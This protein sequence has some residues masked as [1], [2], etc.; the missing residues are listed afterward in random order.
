[1]NPKLLPAIAALL[2]PMLL[3]QAPSAQAMSIQSQ[4]GVA[5]HYNDRFQG[6]PTASGEPYD[7]QKY[8][9]AHKRL[10]L[11]T[12]VRV[13]SLDTGKSTLVR[14]NDRGP[15]VQGR[16]IDLS[17]R[18]ARDL[19]LLKTGVGRVRIEVIELPSSDRT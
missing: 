3:T 5:S 2:L 9:A 1:M 19:G 18:A 16:I 13:T 15:F 7:G 14:I 17:R 11:G 8:T 12:R 4:K 10:P 6:R